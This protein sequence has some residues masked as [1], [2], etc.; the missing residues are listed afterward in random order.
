MKVH[1]GAYHKAEA[2][3][4]PGHQRRTAWAGGPIRTLR[5]QVPEPVQAEGFGEFTK[6]RSSEVRRI[7]GT[8]CGRSESHVGFGYNRIVN[9]TVDNKYV[10]RYIYFKRFIDNSIVERR[11]VMQSSTGRWVSGDNFFDRKSELQAL[12]TLV[13]DGNHVLLTGNGVW[14][15]QASLKN[16]GD[17]SGPRNRNGFSFSLTSKTQRARRT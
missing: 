10:E 3:Q 12:K 11:R 7:L 9:E 17:G 1:A 4:E 15:R 2:P 16:W 6:Y 13:D 14:E 5:R 8:A